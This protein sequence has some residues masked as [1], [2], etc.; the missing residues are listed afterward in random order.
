[1][2]VVSILLA[3]LATNR[4]CFYFHKSYILRQ[5]IYIKKQI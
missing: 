1:M 5:K 4:K 2:S 3:D